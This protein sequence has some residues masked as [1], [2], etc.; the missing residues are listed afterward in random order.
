[1]RKYLYSL[2]WS[3]ANNLLQCGVSNWGGNIACVSMG[4]KEEEKNEQN[5]K[6]NLVLFV[7][8]IVVFKHVNLTWILEK[9]KRKG[10][11]L[12]YFSNRYENAMNES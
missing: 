4:A 7:M 1:M 8:L 10:T 11:M 5:Y 3:V 9:K 12:I 2:F 6:Q